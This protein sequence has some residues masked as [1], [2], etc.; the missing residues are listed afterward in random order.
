VAI[1]PTKGA[2]GKPLDLLLISNPNGVVDFHQIAVPWCD[3]D[4]IFLSCC[5]E[6]LRVATLFKSIRSFRDI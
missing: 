6:R 1:F 4:M 3:Y 2:S 5:F